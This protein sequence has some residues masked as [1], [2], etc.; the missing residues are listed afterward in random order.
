MDRARGT[1]RRDPA[2]CLWALYLHGIQKDRVLSRESRDGAQKET[3]RDVLTRVF[4]TELMAGSEDYGKH[5]SGGKATRQEIMVSRSL[6]STR[7]RI[8]LWREEKARSVWFI[9]DYGRDIGTYAFCLTQRIY[10][11]YAD[12][13]APVTGSCIWMNGD[14]PRPCPVDVNRH[15]DKGRRLHRMA[16]RLRDAI[17]ITMTI[18]IVSMRCSIE[19]LLI[20]NLESA[21][22]IEP[23]TSR[24]MRVLHARLFTYQSDSHVSETIKR[25]SACDFLLF[26]FLSAHANRS[27]LIALLWIYFAR[28]DFSGRS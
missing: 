14:V 6:G 23:T 16:I 8:T 5:Y 3:A 15:Q 28:R 7:G 22:R 1:L 26:L 10:T 9:G 21:R 4:V 24:T 2:S 25:F 20:I 19:Y 11:R 27:R 13:A 17:T 18:I 12:S